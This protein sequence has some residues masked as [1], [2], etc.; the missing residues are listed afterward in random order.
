MSSEI[1]ANKSNASRRRVHWCL[2]LIGD[3]VEFVED[4]GTGGHKAPAVAGRTG[5]RSVPRD[6]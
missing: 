2:C 1:T 6:P 4:N 5:L 3:F